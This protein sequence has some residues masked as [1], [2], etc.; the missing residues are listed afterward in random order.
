MEGDRLAA[1][2]ALVFSFLSAARLCGYALYDHKTYCALG[3]TRDWVMD[4]ASRAW[5]LYSLLGVLVAT[6]IVI[7]LLRED[8]P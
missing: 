3:A 7:K 2:I 4:G 5:W 1:A 8:E 6:M